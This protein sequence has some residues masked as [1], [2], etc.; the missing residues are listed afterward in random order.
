MSVLKGM[1]NTNINVYRVFNEF[2][3]E[4]E[5]L[6]LSDTWKVY[7]I[8]PLSTGT[9]GA[10]NAEVPPGISAFVNMMSSAHP[11]PEHNSTHHLETIQDPNMHRHTPI[12]S[13]H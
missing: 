13:P 4:F 5:Y 3:K 11:L 7:L 12:I 9:I 8:E 10:V 1:D 6:T 2:T